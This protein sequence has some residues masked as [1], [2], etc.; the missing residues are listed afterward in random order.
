[1]W[2]FYNGNHEELLC[3]VQTT[4]PAITETNVGSWSPGSTIHPF[5]S[6]C[7]QNH[8]HELRL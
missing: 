6:D 2:Q 5:Q 4:E 8:H 3:E 7:Q 1:V